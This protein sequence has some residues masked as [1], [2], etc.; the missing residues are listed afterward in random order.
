MNTLRVV[1]EPSPMSEMEPAKKKSLPVA[2]LLLLRPK[3]WAKNLLVFAAFL[4]T[5]G[6]K[7]TFAISH[8]LVAFFAMCFASSATYIFN[9]LADIE[10][11]RAHPKKRYR[12]LASGSV[13]VPVAV[14]IGAALLVA[15]LGMA[16][17]LNASSVVIVTVYLILQV[18][19]NWKLKHTPIADVY[20][21]AVG[22]VLRAVLGAA[23]ISVA[24]SPWLLFC[25]GALALMLGFA[26]RRNEFITQGDDRASSRESL[27][28][29]SKLSLDALVIMFGTAAALC[30]G[31]Y[32]IE[33]S[34]AKKFPGIILTS[35]FVFYGITRYVLLVFTGDEGGEP[36]D[37]LFKDKHII[38]SVVLFIVAAIAAVSGLPIHLLEQ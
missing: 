24:I 33:S 2:S 37:V 29:Y 23:A 17:W 20:T 10:R 35:L 16:G 34:T 15:S 22:F 28:H 25:T 12:P 5:G 36:A 26:K 6:F 8:V 30:Y 4:F 7:D 32:C 38:A 27:V 31:L 11:D 9:D 13:P 19:Y 1:A 3:Q 21:I 18:L 14:G